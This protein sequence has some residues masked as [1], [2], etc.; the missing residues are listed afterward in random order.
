MKE[1]LARRKR[2]RRTASVVFVVAFVALL[3]TVALTVPG[4]NPANAVR[5]LRISPA[6]RVVD[7][8]APTNGLTDVYFADST[9][10]LGLEQHCVLSPTAD[11]ECSLAIV[12]TNDAGRMWTPV[13]RTL[14]VT[15]PD[16]HASYPF[17]DFVT[18]G[19]DGWIYGS[20]SF[21]TH[22]GGK[23]LEADGP[24]V[25]V[26]DLSIVGN[27]TWALSRPC[28]PGIAGCTSTLFSTYGRGTVAR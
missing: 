25:L 24:G 19:K 23:T 8:T 4:Q 27:E 21:V 17:I 16:S 15:Y 3:V 11:T 7:L 6:T 2:A 20:K 18:N 14:H 13:G 26:M 1:R 28:P 9:H 5:Y 12:R 22:D 10:G